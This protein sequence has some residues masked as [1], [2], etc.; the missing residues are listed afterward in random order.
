MKVRSCLGQNDHEIVQFLM[1]GD[2]RKKGSKTATLDFQKV[3]FEPFRM[4]VRR[5][6]W[7]SVLEGRESRK[8]GNSSRRKS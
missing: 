7:D 6:P 5:V 2:I 3:D 1:L 4:V 8:V